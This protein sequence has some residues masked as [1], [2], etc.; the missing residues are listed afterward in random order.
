MPKKKTIKLSHGRDGSVHEFAFDHALRL[1]RLQESKNREDWKVK[2][3]NWE[4]KDNEIIRRTSD[5]IDGEA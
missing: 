4:F 1:L 5:S 2:E 3:K